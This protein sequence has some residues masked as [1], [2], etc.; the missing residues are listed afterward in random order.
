MNGKFQ[1]PF[2][3]MM[4]M[5]FGSTV[6]ILLEFAKSSPNRRPM[7]HLAME[8]PNLA[9]D[10][11][12]KVTW[13]GHSASL[14]TID[15]KALLLDP[16]FGKAPSP[17]PW[18]GKG[19]YSGGLPFEIGQLPVID[20]VVLSHDHYDHLDYGTIM[21]I[22]H[23]VNKFLVPLGVGGHLI[24]WGVQP[25]KIEEHDWW[26]EFTYEGL[27][28]ACTPATHFSGRS[29]TDRGASLWC[30]WVIKGKQSNIFFSGDSGYSSHFKEIG[31]KYGPFDLTLMECGQYDDRWS[32]IHMMPEETVQAH[33]DV[34]G[35][36]ML[37]IH[38]GA[39][40]LALHDWTDPIERAAK[41]AHAIKVSILTPKIGQTVHVNAA[42]YPIETWWK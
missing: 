39:F 27:T 19:R 23:K 9:K 3:T 1:N 2:P 29:M 25:E 13:F 10:M 20:A 14:L 30:S 18:L 41:A 33:L 42:D 35:K 21:K 36:L 17:F 34:K 31:Q 22:K 38:W 28:L 32:D 16:M 26:D 37:P 4:N 24:R 12:T 11:E 6:G 40:T 15:G 8:T 5:G 7:T